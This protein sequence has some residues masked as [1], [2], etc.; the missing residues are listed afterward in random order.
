MSTL[1]EEQVGEIRALQKRTRLAVLQM[2]PH[3]AFREQGKLLR[4]TDA[5]L[6]RL[7]QVPSD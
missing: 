6:R 1:T 2:A 5:L 4:D 7:L 3:E